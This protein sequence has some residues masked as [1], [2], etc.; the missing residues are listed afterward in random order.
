MVVDLM[1]YDQ[2]MC[3]ICAE[4]ILM[5]LEI[6]GVIPLKIF[7]HLTRTVMTENDFNIG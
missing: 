5:E 4:N 6:M 2:G 3:W 1:T 7:A